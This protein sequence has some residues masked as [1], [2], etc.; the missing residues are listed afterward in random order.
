[1]H[2]LDAFDAHDLWRDTALIVTSDRDRELRE[3]ALFGFS[4]GVPL[5]KVPVTERSPM[6][7]NYGP[8]ACSN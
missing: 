5:P 8:A 4:K 6:Y 3:A 2:L 7:R 1:M